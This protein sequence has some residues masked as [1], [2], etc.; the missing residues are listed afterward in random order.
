MTGNGGLDIKIK[1]AS[2]IF[3]IVCGFF[4][5]QFLLHLCIGKTMMNVLLA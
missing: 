2:I 4:R 1:L 3:R 5:P